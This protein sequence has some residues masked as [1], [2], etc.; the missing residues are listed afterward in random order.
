MLVDIV[1]H[2]GSIENGPSVSKCFLLAHFLAPNLVC[3]SHHQVTPRFFPSIFR[4]L[5]HLVHT[6]PA[7]M[8]RDFICFIDYFIDNEA[9]GHSLKLIFRPLNLTTRLDQLSSIFKF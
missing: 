6:F 7:N 9:L 4:H 1:F 2:A 3:F 5:V 8:M